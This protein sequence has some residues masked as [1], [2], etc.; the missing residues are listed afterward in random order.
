MQDTDYSIVQRILEGDSNAFSEIVNNYKK[1]VF[2][3]CYRMVH[4]QEEAEDLAQ[5]VFI[6]AYNHLSKYNPQFKF[7]T[8]IL[9][10]ATNTTIDFVR[11]KKVETLPLDE[12]ISTKQEGASAEIIFFHKENKKTIEDAIKALPIEYRSLIVLFHQ[13]GLSYNEI[14]EHLNI[15]LSKVKNRLHRARSILKDTLQNV[16]KEESQWTAKQVQI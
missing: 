15:P 1:A 4:N 2:S 6:K 14:S 7:S 12:E 16:K 11:K 5:E 8:W 13:N 9:K 3:L 10:I